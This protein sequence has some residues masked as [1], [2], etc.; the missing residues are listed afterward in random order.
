MLKSYLLIL[1]LLMF[2][3]DLTAQSLDIPSSRWGIS[4]GNSKNFTGLRFNYRDRDVEEITGINVTLWKG[5]ENKYSI[6]RGI[7]IGIIPEAA[8]LYGLNLG[9]GGPA[10][11]K[12]LSG[13]EI[14][15]DQLVLV[16]LHGVDKAL[17]VDHPISDA[18]VMRI[19]KKIIHAVSI[20]V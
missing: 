10:A 17:K 11:E 7:S 8:Y 18:C 16:E 4:F 9:L 20:K 19:T 15:Q 14:C 2:F 3:I 12:E 5:D 1:T 13:R 6:V